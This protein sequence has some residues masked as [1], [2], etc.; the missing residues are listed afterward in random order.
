MK[1]YKS[2]SG[3]AHDRAKEKVK[4]LKGFYTH[5]AIYLIFVPFFIFLNFRSTNFPWAI[6]PIAG[7]GLGV[8]GHPTETFGWNLFFGKNWE[9]RKIREY[10][11]NDKSAWY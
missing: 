3:T 7:W 2:I 6:F 1:T 5:L 9:E 8:L 4:A 11:D 10:I